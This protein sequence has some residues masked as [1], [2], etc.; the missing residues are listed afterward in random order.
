MA[1][2]MIQA[3]YTQAGVQGL[4]K[5]GAASRVDHIGQ[6]AS[7]LGGSL[8]AFYWAFG[9]TDVVAIIDLPDHQS[10]AGMAMAVAAGGAV[11]I[12]TT[13]LLTA[14]DV[15][16]GIGKSVPYRPPGT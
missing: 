16:A 7:G 8:E 14:A 13:V 5:E 1:K 11:S 10:A 9:A 15:D 4:M 3:S 2:Y 6:L 12:Q